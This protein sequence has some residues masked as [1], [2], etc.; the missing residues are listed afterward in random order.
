M[1]FFLVL[2]LFCKL[3]TLKV[4]VKG[5]NFFLNLNLN[6]LNVF[7]DLRWGYCVDELTVYDENIK[8]QVIRVV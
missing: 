5:S 7:R 3:E 1:A 2:R 6:F 4:S 8:C